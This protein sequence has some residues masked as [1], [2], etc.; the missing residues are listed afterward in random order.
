MVCD[1]FPYLTDM[2]HVI[3]TH[4]GE[5]ILP[6]VKLFLEPSELAQLRHAIRSPIPPIGDQQ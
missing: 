4:R 2:L 1:L 6:F 5:L 3:H